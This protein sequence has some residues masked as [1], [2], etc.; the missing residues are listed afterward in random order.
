MHQLKKWQKEHI[1]VGILLASLVNIEP[2][3][4]QNVQP[5]RAYTV[6]DNS[7]YGFTEYNNCPLTV[8]GTFANEDWR[9]AISAYE[10]AYYM[11]RGWD[12]YSGSSISFGGFDIT[13]TTERPQ[14]RFHNGDT[15]YVVTFRYSDPDV[16]RL[17]VF[18]NG[19]TVLNQ[20]LYRES[21]NVPR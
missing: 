5:C 19:Q 18:Q 6:D 1:W 12:R 13:G 21:N 11:Y 10:P 3:K 4:A 16:I 15:T 7:A 2:V 20:L 9:V 14:Y 17:E 8:R